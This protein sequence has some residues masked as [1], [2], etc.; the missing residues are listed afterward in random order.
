MSSYDEDRLPGHDR[1]RRELVA[2]LDADEP[3]RRRRLVPAVAAGAVLSLVA[4]GVVAAQRWGGPETLPSA[5]PTRGQDRSAGVPK[6]TAEVGDPVPW[7]IATRMLA[8][9]LDNGSRYAVSPPQPTGFDGPRPTGSPSAKPT[10]TQ[11]SSGPST[12]AATDLPT[13]ATSTQSSS[14]TWG[15][16]PSGP[17]APDA[18]PTGTSS[19]LPTAPATTPPG[20]GG[21]SYL[22]YLP[23]EKPSTRLPG[24]HATGSPDPR[25]WQL[26]EPASAFE[27][28]FTAWEPDGAGGLRPFVLGKADGPGLVVCH[29]V[30]PVPDLPAPTRAD[31]VLTGSLD[32]R[33]VPVRASNNGPI[34][35]TTWWG[36]TTDKAVRIELTLRDGTVVPVVIR[37]GI[38]FGNTSNTTMPPESPQLTAFDR[39]NAVLPNTSSFH[40]G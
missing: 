19:D 34:T 12:G 35:S 24:E 6:D 4:V 9:C 2:L 20:S 1:R 33:Q 23:S 31:G 30:P 8:T 17:G 11:R 27:P 18:K 13:G 3:D 40:W 36:R 38:W 25:V 21:Q 37:D 39:T 29:G 10:A 15:A 14:S 22:P 5:G 28:Y 32:S 16:P 26:R 7:D